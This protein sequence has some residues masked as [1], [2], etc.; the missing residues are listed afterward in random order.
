M[1]AAQ[2]ANTTWFER[3]IGRHCRA[4]FWG[5]AEQDEASWIQAKNRDL[6]DG[7]GGGGGGGEADEDDEDDEE[8]ANFLGPP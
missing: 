7:G 6:H 4:G 8:E 5:G 3:G 1:P 2:L